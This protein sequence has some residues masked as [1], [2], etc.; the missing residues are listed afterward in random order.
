MLTIIKLMLFCQREINISTKI[1]GEVQNMKRINC[2]K[3]NYSYSL[4]YYNYKLIIKVI[5]YSQILRYYWGSKHT[6]FQF[7]LMGDHGTR[8]LDLHMI[9]NL[10]ITCWHIGYTL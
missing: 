3:T 7:F 8:S 9:I 1:F 2:R 6:I 4:H 5:I 10:E